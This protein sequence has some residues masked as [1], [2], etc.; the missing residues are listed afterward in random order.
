MARALRGLGLEVAMRRFAPSF[1]LFVVVLMPNV[2]NAQ[3]DQFPTPPP[4]VNA[5]TASWQVNGQPV[6]FQGDLYYPTA[7][8]VFFDAKVMIRI[9]TCEGVRSTRT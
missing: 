2:G 1:V 9:G 6:L 8:R 5:A 4:R 3:A 7:G